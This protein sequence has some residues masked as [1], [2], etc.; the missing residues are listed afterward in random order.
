M[1]LIGGELGRIALGDFE[2]GGAPSLVVLSA[3]AIAENVVQIQFN[4]PVYYSGLQDPP[5]SSNSDLYTLTPVAGTVGYDGNPTRPVSVA[6]VAVSLAGQTLP[7][8]AI[9]GT[10]LDLT[11][12]RPMTPFPSQ[13]VISAEGLFSADLGEALSG[14][15]NSAQLFGLFKGLIPASVELPTP[16]RDFSNPQSLAAAQSNL[17]VPS[18]PS[19]LG[20]FSVDDTGDYA[21]DSGMISFKKRVYRRLITNPGGFLHLGQSYGVGIPAQGKKLARAAVVQALAGAA[22]S[23]I[24]QEP[25][26]QAVKV[27]VALDP[28]NPGLVRF[29]IAIQTKGG[30]SQKY[31]APF[32]AG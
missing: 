25:E 8:N 5:D 16:T 10:C 9:A 31:S 11:L 13:Y 29:N 32:Q 27:L 14:S 4:L 26:T 21:F 18:N 22:E 6:S 19:F 28:N 7:A 3:L 20:V 30:Q 24:G 15:M 17:P 12:D 23:Q 2:L 1:G